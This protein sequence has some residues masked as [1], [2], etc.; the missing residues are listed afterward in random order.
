M[1]PCGARIGPA[2]FA[3]PLDGK[4]RRL[5]IAGEFAQFLA[6]RQFIRG[7]IEI[8][9]F[10]RKLSARRKA[11]KGIGWRGPCHRHSALRHTLETVTIELAA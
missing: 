5:G 11:R 1:A 9:K 7:E 3:Y 10:M 4:R 6:I 2:G 8:G